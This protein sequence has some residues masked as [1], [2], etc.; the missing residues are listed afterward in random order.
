MFR[1]TNSNVPNQTE[2]QG[3]TVAISGLHASLD[4]NFTV[5]TYT[6]GKTNL[7]ASA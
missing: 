1:A 7:T 2:P 5:T 4:Y 3:T 6:Q